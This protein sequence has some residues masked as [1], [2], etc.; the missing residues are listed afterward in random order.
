MKIYDYISINLSDFYYDDKCEA[1][2][3]LG[4]ND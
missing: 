3:S 1:Y 2:L 4:G